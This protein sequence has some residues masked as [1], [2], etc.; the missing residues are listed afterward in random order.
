MK[1]SLDIWKH[2][3]LFELW[4]LVEIRLIFS[5]TKAMLCKWNWLYSI[6]YSNRFSIMVQSYLMPTHVCCNSYRDCYNSHYW[7]VIS[8]RYITQERRQ[9]FIHSIRKSHQ[10]RKIYI[11]LKVFV[12]TF[13][14]R[15]KSFMLKVRHQSV[16]ILIERFPK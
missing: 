10:Y 6:C 8:R 16:S 15:C 4:M 9:R 14:N 5:Y 2:V 1:Y 3:G 13:E 11:I 7:I 12:W